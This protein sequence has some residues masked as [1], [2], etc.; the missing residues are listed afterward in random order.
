MEERKA[1][2]KDK[3]FGFF[4]RPSKASDGSQDLMRWECGIPG[5]SGTPW[6][7]GVYP[8][9]MQFSDDYPMKPPKCQ[10]P[11][12]FFH[13]NIYP[14]GTVCLSLLNED[15]DWQPS[16]SVKQL[17]CAI[18]EL[19]SAPNVSDP[20]QEPAFRLYIKDQKDYLQKVKD[21]ARKYAQV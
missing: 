1:F 19:L 21:Q 6:E 5:K 7:S 17:L 11:A 2:R 9:T 14:S 10:F 16:V 20:A 3:P 18:Q 4:A 13:P 8:L 15:A 12:G